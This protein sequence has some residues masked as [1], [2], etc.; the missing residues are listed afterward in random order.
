MTLL[1]VLAAVLFAALL[2]GFGAGIWPFD[3]QPKQYAGMAFVAAAL[4][5]I[6]VL[7]GE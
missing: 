6:F 2:L 5:V 3:G 1:Q 4:V 7:S